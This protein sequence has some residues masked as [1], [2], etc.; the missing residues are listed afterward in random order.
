MVF[1]RIL[2]KYKLELS[3][4]NILD[5]ENIK[6]FEIKSN[7]YLVCEDFSFDKDNFT[8][9]VF[10]KVKKLNGII[11]TQKNET[12]YENKIMWEIYNRNGEKSDFNSNALLCLGKY[13]YDKYEIDN[14]SLYNI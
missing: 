6:L 4:D 9:L 5:D 1:F 12:L 14:E 8:K 10:D 7:N 2:Q 11:F 13:I 3:L